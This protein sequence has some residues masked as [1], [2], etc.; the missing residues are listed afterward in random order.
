MYNGNYNFDNQRGKKNEAKKIYNII[1]L[2]E[3]RVPISVLYL[4]EIVIVNETNTK[5]IKIIYHF[6]GN[7]SFR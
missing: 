3:L 6:F 7:D 1:F 2:R 5:Y 4:L